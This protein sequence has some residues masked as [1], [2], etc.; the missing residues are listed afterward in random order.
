T[1]RAFACDICGASF[2]RAYDCK[3]HRDIHTRQGGHECPYCHKT[4]SRADAL[5]RHM[6]RGC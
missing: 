4:L 1:S 6:E 3:R 5:K 2:S